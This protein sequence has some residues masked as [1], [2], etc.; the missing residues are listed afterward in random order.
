M[1]FKQYHYMFT[2]AR[3]KKDLVFKTQTIYMYESPAD[4]PNRKHI[5]FK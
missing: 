4:E 2:G 3:P 5:R 1:T